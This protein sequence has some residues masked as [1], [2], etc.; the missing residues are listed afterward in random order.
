MPRG[1][2][3]TSKRISPNEGHGLLA[4]QLCD[5][6]G[7]AGEGHRKQGYDP[8]SWCGVGEA[9]VA[10]GAKTR[11]LMHDARDYPTIPFTTS[12]AM[13]VR[14]TSS[15]WNFTFS[16][17]WSIPQSASIVAW[18]SWTLTGFSTAR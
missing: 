18:R 8:E 11:T 12:P 9:P 16:R 6:L 2:D 4:T 13:P 17:L 7:P 3:R 1:I 14:R 10:S 5:P 15:P